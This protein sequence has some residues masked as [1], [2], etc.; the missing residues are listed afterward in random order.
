MSFPFVQPYF[1][2][3]NSLQTAQASGG[4][5]VGGWVE[6]GRTTL[7]SVNS[8]I[9]VTSLSDKR[10][11]MILMNG[12]GYSG[13]ANTHL[14]FNS[15]SGTNYSYRLSLNGTGDS[16]GTSSNIA[17]FAHGNGSTNNFGVGYVSNLSSKEK[18]VLSHNIRQ[19][20]A[21]SGTA[22]I[23]S[24]SVSKWANTSSAISGINATTASAATHGT[25]S[26]CV[27]LGWDPA[28][29]HT[30]NF[31]EE[32]ASANATGSELSSGTFTAKKYLWVQYYI[33]PT[34]G[35][36]NGKIH[37]NDDTGTNYADRISYEG[38]EDTHTSLGNWF[39]YA[40]GTGGTTDS[41]NL[42]CNMFIIN[43]SANEKLAI[44]HMVDTT[45]GASTA[46]K[47]I[48]W[49]NKWSN[50]SSQITKIDIDRDGGTGTYDSTSIIKVWGAN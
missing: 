26:E 32:L 19:S 48:E 22:P 24:E 3:G 29:T 1:G 36:V 27:V 30:T 35:T 40:R 10:Y 12:I 20:T 13:T 14:R 39:G 47:R 11:Y 44:Q 50:T 5:A 6:L 4:G 25:G 43:N 37:L 18:L 46:P 17:T 34:G 2:L 38:G 23:R 45:T 33:K 9:D 41:A 28:D 31:W 21:G 15:D 49:A 42:F 8:D 16:P 7:G